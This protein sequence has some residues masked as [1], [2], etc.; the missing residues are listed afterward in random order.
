[1]LAIA[2][3]RWAEADGHIRDLERLLQS[4][5]FSLGPRALNVVGNI[6]RGQGRPDEAERLFREALRDSLRH[7]DYP[8][9][10]DSLVGLA[11]ISLEWGEVDRAVR[12]LAHVAAQRTA[13]F[14]TRQRARQMLEKA[15]QR[16][17]P[18]AY[19]AA[20]RAGGD[21]ST[22]ALVRTQVDLGASGLQA[23]SSDINPPKRT[24]QRP[25]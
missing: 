24:D 3:G 20:V 16:M 23:E 2:Q 25:G 21:A 19:E 22:D 15:A 17:P 11:S 7:S 1:M 14:A 10:M 18:D 5:Q 12:Q 6:R 9:A 13:E 8:I 4:R